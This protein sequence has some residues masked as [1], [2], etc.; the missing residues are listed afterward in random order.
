MA[1][2][3]MCAWLPCSFAPILG[4][5]A[6]ARRQSVRSHLHFL[7]GHILLLQKFL[8]ELLQR[9]MFPLHTVGFHFFAQ[10][11]FLCRIQTVVRD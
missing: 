1:A 5:A 2:M 3:V 9:L 11:F 4:W 7:Y 10:H 8:T 6:L